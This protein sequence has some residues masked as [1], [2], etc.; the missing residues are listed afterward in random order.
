MPAFIGRF[1]VLAVLIGIGE[2]QLRANQ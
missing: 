2:R 1:D